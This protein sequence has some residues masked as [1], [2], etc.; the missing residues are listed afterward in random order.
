MPSDAFKAG[1][2]HG[3]ALAA[4]T[5]AKASSAGA[6]PFTLKGLT[7]Q[8][9]QMAATDTQSQVAAIEAQQAA[10]RAA[11][12]DRAKQINLAAQA[13]AGMQ[14]GIGGET[15]AS[16]TAAAKD[17]AGFAQGYSGDLRAAAEAQAAK[18]LEGLQA[19]GGN[20]GQVKNPQQGEQL[21][22][23]LYGLGGAVPANTLLA[24]GQAQAGA[25]RQLP[26]STLGYGQQQAL[27]ALASGDQSAK[28]LIADI[29]NA[30]AG[31]G[32]S[33]RTYLS[34]LIG[35]ANSEAQAAQQAA[36]LPL[37]V[38]EKQAGIAKTV[39]DIEQGDADVRIREANAQSLDTYRKATLDQRLAQAANT[40]AFQAGKLTVSQFNAETAR[41]NAETSARKAAIA[42]KRG[43]ASG[44]LT[45]DGWRGLV[46]D[47]TKQARALATVKAAKQR[48]DSDDKPQPV[49]GTRKDATRYPDA[50]AQIIALGPATARWQKKAAE[51]VNAQ[52]APGEHGRPYSRAQAASVAKAGAAEA[53]KA[54]IPYE[55]ALA[56]AAATGVFPR[57]VLEAALK[58]VYFGGPFSPI[59]GSP[60]F[61]QG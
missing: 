40:A 16:Y 45:P 43:G 6:A 55:Q 47:A 50:L 49:P 53:F 33:A 8:A 31:Q 27:G 11:A 24:A 30:K 7:A 13:A 5:K 12:A 54:G 20:P 46:T 60:R 21:G 19:V 26:A 57:G 25:Q 32:A 48:F 1:Q 34:Q 37:L 44:G 29:I 59:P 35:G 42:A 39:A 4:K 15:A 56:T 14:T 10:L 38:G 23:V 52:Y 28:A 9:Q 22:N 2:A 36:L 3:T 41:I 61:G 58:S 17:I 18:T 51:I